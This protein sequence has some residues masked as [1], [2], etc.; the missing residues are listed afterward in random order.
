[1]DA[2]DI[3]NNRRANDARSY[4]NSLREASRRN[5]SVQ[6]PFPINERG[7]KSRSR[8]HACERVDESATS[9]RKDTVPLL[10]QATQQG[11]PQPTID[12]IGVLGCMTPF[13]VEIMNTQKPGK[14][15]VPPIDH[16]A[17]DTDPEDHL[18]AY[19]AQMSVQTGCEATWCKFFPTTL[20]GLALSWFNSIPARSI[21]SFIV[22][23][24][25][26]L[27]HFIAGK[28]H[29]KT[30]LH[31]MS[32]VQGENENLKTTLRDSTRNP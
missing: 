4:T 2:R 15:K 12:Q 28:R 27:Q 20:K 5:R 32:V 18:A 11:Q 22:L 30:S 21:I 9:G 14:I 16:F 8:N 13:S 10:R 1:M 7:E 29:K 3:I 23:E 26:F 25:F 31:L 19:K 24:G 17:G 6:S